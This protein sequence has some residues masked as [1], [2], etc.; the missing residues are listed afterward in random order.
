MAA[1]S[2]EPERMCCICR[3]KLPKKEL[4]RFVCRT[5]EQGTKHLHPDPG[6]TL[7]GRGFYL[8]SS[9]GCRD[10]LPK[11]RGWQKKCRG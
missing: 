4:A 6:K 10:K 2:H 7:D 8:C 1:S 9:Q 11:F 3:R 5:D